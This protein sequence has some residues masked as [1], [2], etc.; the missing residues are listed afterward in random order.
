MSTVNRTQLPQDRG[1][2][3]Y[4]VSQADDEIW[5][6][7]VQLAP[8]DQAQLDAASPTPRDLCGLVQHAIARAQFGSRIYIEQ[9]AVGVHLSGLPG[10]FD[11]SMVLLDGPA[12]LWFV[13]TL[14]PTHLRAFLYAVERQLAARFP[15]ETPQAA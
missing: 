10:S 4:T 12:T 11:G 7:S 1:L 3:A 15:R 9:I 5:R 8:A 14:S 2:P 13:T 6:V